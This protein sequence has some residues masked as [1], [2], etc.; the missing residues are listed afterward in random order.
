MTYLADVNVWVALSAIGHVH[1]S[2][3]M[4]WFTES[5][6]D[7]I[8]FCRVTQQGFLRLLTN[9]RLMGE[10]VVSAARAWELYDALRRDPRITF[11]PEPPGL[12][13]AWRD[14]TRALHTGANFW[15][16]AY[17]AGFAAAAGFTLVSFDRD[18]RRYKDIQL[19]LLGTK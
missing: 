8:A 1:Y 4:E 13:E 10:N 17:L 14:Q 19:T 5:E 2:S 6:P 7:T 16:D 18:F 3:A 12:E 11:T 15:T 9:P